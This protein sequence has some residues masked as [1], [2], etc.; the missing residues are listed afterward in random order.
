MILM[1]CANCDRVMTNV[2]IAKADVVSATY[3]CKCGAVY[4]VDIHLLHEGAVQL[5]SDCKHLNVEI[6]DINHQ[7]CIDC[8]KKIAWTD[9][10]GTNTNTRTNNVVT[11]NNKTPKVS[12]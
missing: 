9:T 11:L 2:N 3:H 4:R 1:T 10:I 5:Q 12:K 6:W 7:R 8:H